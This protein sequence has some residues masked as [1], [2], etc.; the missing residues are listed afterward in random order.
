MKSIFSSN[1]NLFIFYNFRIY[2]MMKTTILNIQKRQEEEDLVIT[3]QNH[4]VQE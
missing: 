3:F 2:R 4:R 1:I